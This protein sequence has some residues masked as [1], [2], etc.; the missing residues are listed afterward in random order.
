MPRGKPFVCWISKPGSKGNDV[1]LH[2]GNE[3]ELKLDTGEWVQG[4]FGY[5]K[6][7]GFFPYVV[8]CDKIEHQAALRFNLRSVE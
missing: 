7:N 8:K 1:A 3:V 6:N 2:I 4:K 5:R